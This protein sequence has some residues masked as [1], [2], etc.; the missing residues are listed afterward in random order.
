[1][2]A[3]VKGAGSARFNGFRTYATAKVFASWWSAAMAAKHG[4][5]VSVFAVSPGSNTSTNAGRNQTGFKKFAFGR[6]MPLIGR[7]MGMDMPVSEGAKRYLDV[8][9]GTP[10]QYENGA[11]YMS[12]PN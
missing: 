1:M 3:F 12:A 2:L 6:V 5:K 9:H 4:D 10:S 8:L 7:F 11:S